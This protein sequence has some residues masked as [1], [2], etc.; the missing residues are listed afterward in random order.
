MVQEHLP[1]PERLPARLELVDLSP[2]RVTAE[3]LRGL[4]FDAPAKKSIL[5][6][7]AAASSGGIV[8]KV[9]SFFSSSSPA[10][11]SEP[12]AAAA[13]VDDDSSRPTPLSP[14]A[15]TLFLV[16]GPDGMIASV[17]GVKG[18]AQIGGI[19]GE[20]GFGQQQGEEGRREVRRFWN[21]PVLQVGGGGTSGSA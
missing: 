21:A 19:L 1:E 8:S 5:P 10:A 4:L 15:R 13:D 17:A 18:T 2:G 9:T 11:T 14:T 20:L 6:A 7:A 12:A 16:S 3:A